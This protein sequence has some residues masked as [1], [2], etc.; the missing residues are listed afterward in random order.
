VQQRNRENPGRSRWLLP[1]LVLKKTREGRHV[2]RAFPHKLRLQVSEKPVDCPLSRSPGDPG[3]RV[4]TL[5]FDDHEGSR[6]RAR[7]R[8]ILR[9]DEPRS[10]AELCVDGLEE[11]FVEPWVHG[12][13]MWSGGGGRKRLRRASGTFPRPSRSA[14]RPRVTPTFCTCPACIEPSVY[15]KASRSKA[16]RCGREEVGWQPESPMVTREAGRSL[17]A[18]CFRPAKQSLPPPRSTLRSSPSSGKTTSWQN[19]LSGSATT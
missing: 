5:G 14:L 3:G 9:S 11:P 2:Q 8:R 18:R 6:L 13:K 12:E 16:S 17:P 19:N 4:S 15:R 1:R 7:V 10:G